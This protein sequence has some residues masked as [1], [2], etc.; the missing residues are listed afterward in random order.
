MIFGIVNPFS[1]KA[2]A[3]SSPKS[4]LILMPFLLTYINVRTVKFSPPTESWLVNSNFPRVGRMQGGSS[5][6]AFYY[7]VIYGSP[8]LVFVLTERE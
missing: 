6:D 3:I 5:T 7:D 1:W 8:S 2:I 4:C